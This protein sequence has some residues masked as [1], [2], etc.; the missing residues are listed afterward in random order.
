MKILVT[1]ATSGMGYGVTK[2]LA[3]S[4]L[5]N[6][7]I[8]MAKSEEEGKKVVSE[9]KDLTDNSYI[10]YVV[11]DLSDLKAVDKVITQI[12]HDHNYLDAIFVNAGIGYAKKQI[13]TVNHL[14]PHFQVNYLS[15]FKLVLGLLD[16]LKQSQKGA[17]VIFNA[18]NYGEINYNDLQQNNK[19]SYEK[20]IYQ[21]MAA[22]R[23]FMHKLSRLSLEKDYN[24]S[25]C[26]FHIS[27]TVWTNQL[28]I[29]PKPMKVM[30]TIMKYL[31]QFIST[32]Q[33]GQII[34]PL[35]TMSNEDFDSYQN[36][37]VSDKNGSFI[38][39]EENDD[40]LDKDNQDRLWQVSL[41]LLENV[42]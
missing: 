30:A 27:K 29:I 39:L 8:M 37:L 1:G 9:L 15:Q 34:A 31:G 11:C 18:T 7:L 14:D 26:A 23:M 25:C 35:F 6:E 2:A 19:W 41:D 40:I 17:R 32:D 5:K 24:V 36:Q 20:G 3:E 33:C 16:L 21:A 42:K 38:L 13:K 28:N 10:S 4:D 22:K 12:N